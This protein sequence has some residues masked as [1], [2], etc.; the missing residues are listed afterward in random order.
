MAKKMTKKDY[1]AQLKA[2]PAVAENTALVEFID[3]EVSLLERKNSNTGEKKPTARQTENEAVKE[4][5]KT[6]MSDG[7]RYTIAELLN[8]TPDLP[9]DMTH[10]RMTS[11]LSQL[12][13]DN[14][15]QRVKDKKTTYFQV[16]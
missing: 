4:N 14:A 5:I 15:I 10:S 7:A 2:I 11:L 1:Y 8:V 16:V 12:V 6:V 9:E 13:K 3:H